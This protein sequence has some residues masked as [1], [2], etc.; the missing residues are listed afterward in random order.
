MTAACDIAE[1]AVGLRLDD[2]PQAVRDAACLHLIDAIGVGLASSAGE[3]QCGWPRA[4]H[5]GGGI[6]TCLS[7]GQAAPNEAAMLNGA[8]I[9]ALEYD[10]THTGS[11]IHGSA[12]AAPVALAAAEAEQASGADLLLNYVIAWEVMIR[13]GLAAP[14][15]F[16]ARGFQVTAIAGA[17][18]AAAAAARQR[19]LAVD[20]VAQAIGIAGSQASGLLAFLEDG[21][22]VK[23]LNPGW[24]AQ[25]GIMAASLAASGMTGPAG[26]LDGPLGVMQ[27]FAGQVGDLSEQTA[28]LGRTWHL[29]DAAFKLYPCCHYIHP[30]LEA[31]EQLLAQGLRSEQVNSITVDVAAGQA[32]LI[33]EPWSRR[34]APSSGYDGKWGLAYCIALMLQTGKVDVASF[35]TAPDDAVIALARRIDWRV[36]EHANFPQVFPAH[37]AVE[38][39]KG[40]SLSAAIEDV[41]GTS[42]R[43]VDTNLIEVKFMQNARRC[44]PEV[45]CSSLLATLKNICDAP[46]LSALSAVFHLRSETKPLAFSHAN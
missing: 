18:G 35:E 3:G 6:A 21:S 16:Q 37:V 27:V 31:T 12:V 7:G 5:T 38:T 40:A 8:L 34:Q 20:G 30:F 45:A 44:L 1:F 10:D 9:H 43:P 4:M 2:V 32:P 29:P 19:G 17:I 11:V 46:D 26:I 39:A 15:V 41:R 23:A 33:C 13:I 28:T 42:K 36:M 24:A 25:T 22:S 14:G